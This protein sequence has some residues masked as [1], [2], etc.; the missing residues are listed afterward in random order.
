MSY[1]VNVVRQAAKRSHRIGQHRECRVYIPILNGTQE[2]SQFK[3]VM[4]A[5]G[6]ALM[7]E[8]RLDRGELAKYSYDEQSSLATD[9]AQCFAD[10]DLANAWEELAAKE[11]EDV[12]M[13]EEEFFEKVLAERMQELAAQTLKLC[14]VDKILPLHQSETATFDSSEE[15]T[16][17]LFNFTQKD[18]SVSV[19]LIEDGF[20]AFADLT[21]YKNKRSPKAPTEDQLSFVL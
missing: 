15:E 16:I 5:R 2:M 20:I 4:S 11:Y 10:A 8:G 21:K 17:S 12:E 7:T 6:H 1:E 3:K 13:I 14:G 19:E 9:L 18:E